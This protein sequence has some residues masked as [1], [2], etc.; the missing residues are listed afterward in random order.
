MKPMN[1]QER[2]SFLLQY[3][4]VLERWRAHDLSLALQG[5]GD[6][7]PAEM[8]ELQTQLTEMRD[9][10]ENS[11]PVLSLSRCP[12]TDEVVYHSIDSMGLDGLW[13]NYD[14]PV[15]P[16]ETLPSTYFALDGALTL[17]GSIEFAPFLCKPGAGVPGVLPRL[18]NC[19]G[20]KAVISSLQIG[21]HL[22]Y[23]VFYFAL[24][25][26]AGL[27]RVNTWGAGQYTFVDQQ[28]M[29]RWGESA[30][31]ISE[32][33]FALAKWIDSGQLLWIKPGDE[34][35]ALYSGLEGCPY[36]ELKGRR[37]L[38]RVERGKVW[39]GETY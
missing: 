37:E 5:D 38:L 24:D 10:Y 20:I 9:R 33:D 23:P 39:S 36:L 25:V 30:V 12:F 13:W 16:L 6:K 35:V 3:F 1:A 31:S 21:T 19:E 26:P 17:K 4:D 11:L 8:E 32:Y 29:P 22:G 28:N 18:L 15:R 14:A 7:L 2:K 27:E 34:S